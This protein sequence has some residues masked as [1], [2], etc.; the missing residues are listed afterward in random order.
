MLAAGSAHRC[1][2]AWIAAF[3]RMSRRRPPLHIGIA[4]CVLA[5]CSAPAHSRE[6]SAGHPPSAPAFAADVIDLTNVER[7]GHKR[8]PLS[9]NARLTRAA[10]MHAEQMARARQ[11]AHL[12]PNAPYPSAEDRLRAA[13]YRWHTYGENVASGQ[14]SAAQVVKDWMHSRGHR[15]NILNPSFT[16]MGAGYAI[17]RDGRPYHVQVFAGPLS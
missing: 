14:A 1:A 4:V 9:A 3:R 8:Q 17:D 10:Q 2:G 12:L 15:T 7:T 11:L 5:V 13:E 6:T 16:E